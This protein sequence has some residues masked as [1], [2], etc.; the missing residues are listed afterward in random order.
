[1]SHP[2]LI[3]HP[4]GDSGSHSFLPRF[5]ETCKLVGW[6]AKA[7]SHRAVASPA[8]KPKAPP[9][10]ALP[11]WRSPD[12]AVARGRSRAGC[13]DWAWPDKHENPT[14]RGLAL[15]GGRQRTCELPESWPPSSGTRNW[16]ELSCFSK[17]QH[18]HPAHYRIPTVFTSRSLEAAIDDGR[19]LI[20][21]RMR[22]TRVTR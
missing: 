2:Y 11:L 18:Y 3:P 21:T 16:P 6:P 5:L 12:P 9:K 14:G 7:R 4:R 8:A 10:Q 15:H 1:M 13:A 22:R 19:S 17:Q 20:A